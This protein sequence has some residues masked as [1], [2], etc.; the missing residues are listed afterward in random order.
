M[1]LSE[2][3]VK[4]LQHAVTDQTLG[5]QLADAVNA[6]QAASA[7]LSHLIAAVIVA[8]NV[9]QTVDFGAL[10]VGDKVLHIPAVAGNSDF[11]TVATAGTLGVAA[12][13]GDLYV[14]LR[15]FSAPTASNV[16]L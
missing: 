6:G 8:T 13:V 16:K 5:N 2:K 3:L 11:V 15:A 7:Q 9:S 12:V 10:E 14:V 4:R 1:A